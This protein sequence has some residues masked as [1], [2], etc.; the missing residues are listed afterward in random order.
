MVRVGRPPL[1]MTVRRVFWEAIGRGSSVAEAAECAGVCTW[2][3]RRW[4]IQAGGVRPRGSAVRPG[5]LTVTDRVRIAELVQEGVI[6]SRIARALG[7]PVSTITRE[8]A[9]GRDSAGYYLAA[10]AQARA[11]AR[12]ARP[13]ESKLAANP[14][15][16]TEVQARLDRKDSPEQIAGRLRHDFPDD[17]EMW[18]SH[19]S[20]YKALYVQGKGALLSEV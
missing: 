2:T 14:A 12:A 18:V 4:L 11:E 1:P 19:E 8:L 6:P 16:L 13:Q 5:A 17:P 15:L 3:G 9:R 10:G 20:I 7:R